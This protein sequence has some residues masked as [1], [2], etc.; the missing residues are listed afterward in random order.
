MIDKTNTRQTIQAQ[1]AIVDALKDA[2]L[3]DGIVRKNVI[4]DKLVAHIAE[5][6]IERDAWKE[7][8]LALGAGKL[9]SVKDG[10]YRKARG[11][12]A[13]LFEDDPRPSEQ[14][15][16]DYRDRLTKAEII[17]GICES[18]E[19]VKRGDIHPIETL[20]DGIDESDGE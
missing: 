9:K 20:W 6:V 13:E 8:A 14:I 1:Q 15:I 19:Q 18:L 4:I 12:L 16:R 11:C 10:D 7:S 5:M 17:D 2:Q 3:Q